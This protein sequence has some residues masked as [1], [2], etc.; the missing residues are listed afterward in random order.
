MTCFSL[1]AF[2]FIVNLV[3]DLILIQNQDQDPALLQGW[4]LSVIKILCPQP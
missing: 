2:Y 1:P 3:Y 4:Q